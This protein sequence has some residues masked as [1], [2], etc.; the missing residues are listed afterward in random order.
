MKKA[1]T[2]LLLVLF[3]SVLVSTNVDF[4]YAAEE[5]KEGVMP[6]EEGQPQNNEEMMIEN[7]DVIPD[8]M[9]EGGGVEEGSTG[10]NPNVQMEDEEA[11]A[12]SPTATA[13][14]AETPK[15]KM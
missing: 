9:E 15:D 3:L 5:T 12:P 4:T 7:P 8:V 1:V 11:P 6:Q 14:P 13:K 10:E 2:Y